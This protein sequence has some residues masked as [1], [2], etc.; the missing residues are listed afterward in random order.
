MEL[1]HNPRQLV[2]LVTTEMGLEHKYKLN[3]SF[4]FLLRNRKVK[5]Q[6]S[7]PPPPHNSG[8]T[9]ET[10]LVQ[11]GLYHRAGQCDHTEARPVT[12]GVINNILSHLVNY[13]KLLPDSH[14][15]QPSFLATLGCRT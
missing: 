6:C 7:P 1:Y 2:Y 14:Q 9:A 8:V 15:A 11:P 10:R 3:V 4:N 13:Q 5:L 12:I